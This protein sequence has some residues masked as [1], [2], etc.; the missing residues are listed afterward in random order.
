MTDTHLGLIVTAV[1]AL[2][3]GLILLS[4]Y[5]PVLWMYIGAV[6]IGLGYLTVQGTMER[7][8]EE[9]RAYLPAEKAAEPLVAPAPAPAVAPAPGAAPEPAPAPAPAPEAVPQPTPAAPPETQ[10]PEP[11]PATP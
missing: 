9:T 10:A 8:G 2:I 4:R 7:V 11:Q 3:I 1:P 6:A 5:K